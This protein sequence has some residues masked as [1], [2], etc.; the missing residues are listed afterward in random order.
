MIVPIL[1]IAIGLILVVILIVYNLRSVSSSSK[2]SERHYPAAGRAEEN[3][4]KPQS[5]GHAKASTVTQKPPQ[6]V[7]KTERS[8]STTKEMMP[9]KNDSSVLK[10]TDSRETHRS[11]DINKMADHDYRQALQKFRQP[12]EPESSQENSG[13]TSMK[14]EDFRAALRSM[15]NNKTDK[16]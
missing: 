8:T 5:S 12:D 6:F 4:A 15:I 1:S 2:R 16:P 14:D 7:T 9:L 11:A 3:V 13:K 10:R